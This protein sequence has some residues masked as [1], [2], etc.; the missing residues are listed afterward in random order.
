M[1][2]DTSILAGVQLQINGEDYLLLSLRLTFGGSPCP[3][4]FCL[5]SD[6]ITDSINDL[7]ACKYWKPAELASDYVHKI[8]AQ[9]KLPSNIPFTQEK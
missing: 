9:I 8:P 1:N 5:L 4:E 3:P 2:A 6:T 7:M